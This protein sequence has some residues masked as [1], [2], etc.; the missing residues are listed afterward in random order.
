MLLK[1]IRN[2]GIWILSI[3]A[4]AVFE[5]DENADIEKYKEG[6]FVQNAPAIMFPYIRAYISTLTAQSGLF[7]VTLPTFNLL[8]MVDGLKNNIQEVE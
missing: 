6:F 4:V 5:F 8:S 7:T 2:I 1:I 3:V